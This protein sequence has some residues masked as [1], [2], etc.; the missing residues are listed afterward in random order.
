MKIRQGRW[1]Q[2]CKIDVRRD[3]LHGICG[4]SPLHLKTEKNKENICKENDG[5]MKTHT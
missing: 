3:R 2:N 1:R 5:R 4:L